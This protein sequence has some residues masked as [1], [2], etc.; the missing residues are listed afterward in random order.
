MAEIVGL[1]D[2][3]AI[4]PQRVLGEEIS[5]GMCLVYRHAQN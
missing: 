5:S 2:L 4:F 1:V 3:Q